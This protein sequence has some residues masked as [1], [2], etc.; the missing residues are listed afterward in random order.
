ME[1]FLE[2]VNPMLFFSGL[3]F[4]VVGIIMFY[5]PPKNI[6]SLYGYRTKNSMKN[7]KNWDFSQKYSAKLLSLIGMAFV[8]I[9]FARTLLPFNNDQ[10]AIF[11]AIILT[12][13]TVLLLIIVEKAIKRN[14]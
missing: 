3:A 11:G 13:G 6:N 9:S 1:Q 2:F 7:Q 5:F 4:C 12:V 10:H 14:E 8:L